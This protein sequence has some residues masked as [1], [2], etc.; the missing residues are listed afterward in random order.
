MA[1]LPDWSHAAVRAPLPL[2]YVQRSILHDSV[3]A[4]LCYKTSIVNGQQHAAPAGMQ[5]SL[6]LSLSHSV[7]AAKHPP[8]TS[9]AH[10]LLMVICE[11]SSLCCATAVFWEVLCYGCVLATPPRDRGADTEHG[12]Q[13]HTQEIRRICASQRWG[14]G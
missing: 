13:R 7:S 2:A 4:V 5:G 10:F 3:L 12:L 9:L 11:R 1:V 6:S 8:P 14:S